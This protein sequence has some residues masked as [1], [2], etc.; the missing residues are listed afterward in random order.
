MHWISF[1][2]ALYC[3]SC[4]KVASLNIPWLII[5][6]TPSLPLDMLINFL[7][8]L[9]LNPLKIKQ[10][11]P[12]DLFCFSQSSPCVQR[13][14]I[15]I[16]TVYVYYLGFANR[17]P[18]SCRSVVGSRNMKQGAPSWNLGEKKKVY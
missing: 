16:G 7:I 3:F 2:A 9:S 18:S 6:H 1:L 8:N 13:N 14:K 5:T 11:P 12:L 15:I 17:D 4:S 10:R